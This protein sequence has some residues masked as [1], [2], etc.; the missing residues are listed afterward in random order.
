MMRG[1]R[2]FLDTLASLLLVS[3]AT[4]SAEATL[5][6]NYKAG[7][8]SDN[9]GLYNQ[10][11]VQTSTVALSPANAISVSL[12]SAAVKSYFTDAITNS[13][14]AKANDWA[15]RLTFQYS[16]QA[17]TGTFYVD[18]YNAAHD[19]ASKTLG[20]AQFITRYVGGAGETADFLK[21]LQ[22]VQII[23]TDDANGNEK[24]PYVDVYNSGYGKGQALPF[25]YNLA[26][27]T[28][29][30]PNTYVGE[31][32]IYQSNYNLK[33]KGAKDPTNLKYD[34]SFYDWPKRQPN[35]TW[36]A[37]LFLGSYTPPAKPGDKGVVTMYSEGVFW[38][39]N[40]SQPSAN[41]EPSSLLV[42]LVASPFLIGATIVQ[43]RST[44]RAA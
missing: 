14:I 23:K 26:I 19:A 3:L 33:F 41:P 16:N 9:T 22:W 15:N 39:F 44:K 40:V 36:Q 12:N 30:D 32:N 29:L 25:Y 17:L 18:V 13:N 10:F 1:Y 4:Q 7:V 6:L 27:Q 20:G 28:K 37:G 8:G 34:L 42:A 2:P 21:S 5:I 35:H 24:G 11:D 38:G 31:A 43:R